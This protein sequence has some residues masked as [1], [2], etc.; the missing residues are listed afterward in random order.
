MALR[1][2]PDSVTILLSRKQGTLFICSSCIQESHSASEDLSEDLAGDLSLRTA[3]G[4][5]AVLATVD[6]SYAGRFVPRR[7]SDNFNCRLIMFN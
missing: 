2:L 4:S 5:G 3:A 1:S 7:E 6:R